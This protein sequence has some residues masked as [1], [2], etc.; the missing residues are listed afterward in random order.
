MDPFVIAIVG[1]ELTI[2]EKHLHQLR[3]EPVGEGREGNVLIEGGIRA[4]C[5]GKKGP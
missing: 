1:V 4:V 3:N 5:R 2:R